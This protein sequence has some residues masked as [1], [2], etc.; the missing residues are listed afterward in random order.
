MPL[1]ACP[2]CGDLIAPDADSCPR[3]GNTLRRVQRRRRTRQRIVLLFVVMLAFA[4]AILYL[5]WPAN[6]FFPRNELPEG[7]N[8][9]KRIR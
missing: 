2:Q 4:V 6:G 9:S 3:C 1:I 8:P 7:P 5:K